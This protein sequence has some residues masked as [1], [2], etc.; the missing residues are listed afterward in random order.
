ELVDASPAP[1][2][3]AHT[4]KPGSLGACFAEIAK[5]VPRA[6]AISDHGRTLT[7]TEL[8]RQSLSVAHRLVKL[9][10]GRG[11]VVGLFAFRSIEAV[12]GILGILQAG[13]AYL[14]LDPNYPTDR[15]NYMLS[16]S[17]VRILVIDGGALDHL[18][19]LRR[20]CDRDFIAVAVADLD[21]PPAPLNLPDVGPLDLAYVLYTSGS[22]GKPKGVMGLHGATLNRMRWMWR[23]FPFAPDDIG[24]VKTSLSFGDTFWEI[25]GFL[26]AGR[27]VAIIDDHEVRDPEQ[28]SGAIDREA[29]TRLTVVPSLVRMLLEHPNATVRKRLAIIRLWITSG[30]ALP[31]SLLKAFENAFPASRLLNLYGSSEVAADATWVELTGQTSVPIGCVLPGFVGHVLDGHMR[32]VPAGIVGEL[33]LG[34]VGLA[35]GYLGRGGLTATRF[36]A[37]PYGGVGGRLYRTGDLVRRGSDGVLSYVGRRDGQV[38]VR[39]YR[40][41]PGEV[42]AALLSSGHVVSCAVVARDDRVVGYVVGSGDG[43]AVRDYVRGVLPGH[44]V[45]SVL[46][47]LDRLPVTPSGKVDRGGLPAAGDAAAGGSGDWASP[48][49]LAGAVAELWSDLLGGPRVGLGDDFFALGG[50]SLLATR[51]AG[52]TGVEVGV[53]EIFA[54]PTLGSLVGRIEGLRGTGALVPAVTSVSRT[55][56]LALSYA[57]SRLWFLERLDAGDGA[58]VRSRYHMAQGV[59]L[60][61]ALDVGALECALGA[62]VDR[63]EVLRTRLVEG[64]SGPEQRID[65]P[66]TGFALARL[67]AGSRDEALAAARA[68]AGSG[69]DLS[70]E[71]PLRGCVIGL[72]SEDHVLVLVLHH[73]AGD[74]W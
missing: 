24:A 39:G 29:I 12:A 74:G 48:D 73:V 56:A 30:E 42:E 26:C 47:W 40:I 8:Q 10:I 68:F 37:D 51:L 54:H 16:D 71:W 31:L 27:P 34:G 11:D 52:L 7:F 18:P 28:F 53:G 22:T 3:P 25:L 2:A 5:R 23:Q 45:P 49:G 17:G 64:L 65:E 36:V 20:S 15:L 61:G 43:A 41:E 21:V 70:R 55:G 63:H 4:A 62:L 13:A 1:P 72:G 33:Y 6:V 38:K 44:L 50:H 9:G 19:N 32:V 58:G 60:R 14:P 46:V 66:G 67:A 59:W 69:F 35:R 57:Q